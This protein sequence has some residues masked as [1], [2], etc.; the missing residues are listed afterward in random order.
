MQLIQDNQSF[1]LSHH[2]I[3]LNALVKQ[4]V[5]LLALRLKNSC[6]LSVIQWFSLDWWQLS[7]IPD[8]KK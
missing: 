5:A 6:L 7:I 3:K 1:H 2:N 4:I 8:G